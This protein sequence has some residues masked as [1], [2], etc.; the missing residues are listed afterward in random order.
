[1]GDRLFALLS[2]EPQLAQLFELD[3]C[4][5]QFQTNIQSIHQ[6]ESFHQQ[7]QIVLNALH[8]SNQ[9]DEQPNDQSISSAHNSPIDQSNNQLVDDF[10]QFHQ[11]RTSIDSCSDNDHI[12]QSTEQHSN[13]SSPSSVDD[14]V[15]DIEAIQLDDHD[16]SFEHVVDDCENEP[17]DFNKALDTLQIEDDDEQSNHPSHLQQITEEDDDIPTFTL[18]INQ[19]NEYISQSIVQPQ[20]DNDDVPIRR[21]ANRRRIICSSEDDSDSELSIQQPISQSV[22]LIKQPVD[23]RIKQSIEQ[24]LADLSDDEVQSVDQSSDEEP[25][26]KQ[27]AEKSSDE[28]YDFG[29]VDQSFD[30]SVNQSINQSE[31]E[32]DVEIENIQSNKTPAKKRSNNQPRNGPSSLDVEKSTKVV[33]SHSVSHSDS[34]LN[35]KSDRRITARN[36]DDLAKQWF[37]QLNKQCFNQ[38]LPPIDLIWSSKLRTTA[39]MCQC[40]NLSRSQ[41]LGQPVDPRAISCRLASINLSVKVIDTESKLASTL[42]HEMCHAA[43]FMIDNAPRPPHG[44]VFMKWAKTVQATHQSIQVT[45]CHSYDIFYRFR[46]QCSDCLRIIGRHSNSL[47][48]NKYRCACGGTIEELGAF[49]RDGTPCKQRKVSEYQQ[50]VKDNYAAKQKDTPSKDVMKA[51]AEEWKRRKGQSTNVV[52]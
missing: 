43:A 6:S 20:D 23:Q 47:D 1:M 28:E 34:H 13:Q 42:A 31:D 19:Q 39:G 50:F 11:C 2:V 32:S 46:Y 44:N 37:I 25:E 33:K 7:I 5:Y 27:S 36:R 40:C 24:S 18:S 10:N 3:R 30:E 14:L 41:A 49:N 51:L 8:H 21:K 15:D 48:V 29:P 45:V 12:N 35:A 52:D 26:S 4:K 22:P 16:R 17:Y 9:S 38:Q